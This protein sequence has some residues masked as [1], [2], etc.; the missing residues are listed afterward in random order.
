M[1]FGLDAFGRGRNA[2][3]HADIELFAQLAQQGGVGEV[4]HAEAELVGDVALGLGSLI[5]RS[6]IRATRSPVVRMPP[7][8][9]AS[10]W[11]SDIPEG[12]RRPPTSRRRRRSQPKRP[13]PA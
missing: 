10:A 1:C 12:R 13:R 7:M 6:C 2:G 9:E 5:L 11:Q 3:D 4:A 8:P